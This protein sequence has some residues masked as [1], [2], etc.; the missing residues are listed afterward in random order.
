MK[1]NEAMRAAVNASEAPQQ[2]VYRRPRTTSSSSDSPS[3]LNPPRE[4]RRQSVASV[5]TVP[6]INIQPPVGVVH[7]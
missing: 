3:A 5:Y 2:D 4:R 1:A 6:D 7:S